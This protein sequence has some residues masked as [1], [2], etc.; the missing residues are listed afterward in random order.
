MNF[1]TQGFTS[2]L[3]FITTK[4]TSLYKKLDKKNKIRERNMA[5]EQIIERE[6]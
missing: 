1:L 5:K 3:R 6:V 4:L 2:K